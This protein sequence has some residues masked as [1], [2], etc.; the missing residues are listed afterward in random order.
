MEQKMYAVPPVLKTIHETSQLR[1]KVCMHVLG[2]ARTDVRVM[3]EA[4]TL[5][6]AGMEVSI[7]DIEGDPTRPREEE[8]D[9]IH[10]KHIMMPQWFVPARFKPWFLV[11]LFL[12]L[13]SGAI[14]LVNVP[15]DI[16]HAHDD[17]ALPAC[18]IAAR[19]RRKR[20]VFDAHELPLVEPNITRWRLLRGLSA[21]LLRSMMSRCT[22]II[23][24]SPPIVRE[25]Q[26]LYGGRT[27]Q[28]IRNIPAYQAPISS[29]RLR[30][31]L[32]LDE[33]IRIALYQGNLDSRGLHLLIYA[34]RF[35]DP[36]IVIVMMGQ[37]ANQA[38]LEALIAREGVGERVKIIP[39]VPYAELLTW[40]ASADIGLVVYSP[41]STLTITPNI[42]MC[43]PNKLFEYLMAGLP[44][45]ASRLDAVADI[46][47]TYNVGC[48]VDSLEPD[49][50]GQAINRMLAN[51]DALARMKSN[52]KAATRH[53][54]CWENEG[55]RLI[56]FYRDVTQLPPLMNFS[57][58]IE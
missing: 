50:I 44:V 49:D 52:A 54:L 53:D 13:L 51:H 25:L 45:L 34:A 23:T 40:T 36:G 46:I 55:R 14:A 29:N 38:D 41:V 10:V 42:Q 28:L 21:L 30:Q 9:G 6:Q 17:T 20:L 32:E 5:Q 37:G 24:V 12:I 33:G 27:A 18:Y 58:R 35:I 43:L 26:R 22:G 11:K 3:R 31:Y 19:L 56:D 8:I 16:Y 57:K 39:P 1:G 2:T 47:T 15:A 4:T 48:I 7:V